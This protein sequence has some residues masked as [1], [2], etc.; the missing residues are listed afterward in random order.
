MNEKFVVGHGSARRTLS[1]KELGFT[2]WPILLSAL[3]VFLILTSSTWYLGH[4]STDNLKR[5]GQW[6][7]HTNEVRL[8]IAN[9][10]IQTHATQ[11]AARAVIF[12]HKD[13]NPQ[14]HLLAEKNLNDSL[15][16]L[17]LLTKDNPEQ[18]E[19]LRRMEPLLKSRSAF[20][21]DITN[22]INVDGE[23][24]SQL[25]NQLA[26]ISN[27]LRKEIQDFDDHEEALLVERTATQTAISEKLE[28]YA[29]ALAIVLTLCLCAASIIIYQA[30]RKFKDSV[31]LQQ[32]SRKLAEEANRAKSSFVASVTHELRTPLTSILG[33]ADVLLDLN[34]STSDRFDAIQTIRRNGGHL[35]SLVNDVLDLSKIEASEFKLSYS[36]VDLLHL[37]ADIS[38]LM[39]ERLRGK[40]VSM[41]FRSST[42][43]SR[44]VNTDPVRVKQVIVNLLGNAIKF[45]DRG[46]VIVA[47]SV[48]DDLLTVA[49]SDTG[50]GMTE[51]DQK[52]LFSPFFQ[53]DGITSQAYGGTGLGLVISRKITELFDG[54]L[55][56]FSKKQAGSTFTF[57][58]PYKP[59]G[60]EIIKDLEQEIGVQV[61]KEEIGV[62]QSCFIGN[63][64]LVE[65]SPDSRRLIER[66]LK[67]MG[68]TISSADNGRTA[69]EMTMRAFHDKEPYDLVLMDMQLPEIDGYTA[70]ASLRARGYDLPIVALT[71]NALEQDRRRALDVGCSD[72]LAKPIDL[73]HMRKVFAQ[74][75]K[76]GT[77]PNTSL[78]LPVDKDLLLMF[79]K[80]IP[81]RQAILHNY[82]ITGNLLAL[83]E[84]AHKL[85]SAAGMYGFGKVADL[86][87]EVEQ[88]AKTDA[89]N[90]KEEVNRLCHLLGECK[91]S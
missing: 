46:A 13:T 48:E 23:R 31:E 26:E 53:G 27:Q 60:S 54:R 50:V 4:K 6:V 76:Q 28:M 35:L 90:L 67:R 71:A 7:S 19:R 84:E 75:L 38:S 52:R 14:L 65:D 74:Y 5:A 29:T 2:L 82:L 40:S 43:F 80:G 88:L 30:Y 57:S 77:G 9:F 91:I 73:G 68:L 89:P 55:T 64:L 63:I 81:E 41:I 86:S 12:G 18:Q 59:E 39:R 36:K 16:A 21:E 32:H 47:V 79:I 42:P 33:F 66:F 83:A 87:R 11:S 20:I 22:S 49:I 70:V 85:I 25:L 15:Q 69:I 58:I 51:E 10:L 56:V 72:F 37:F 24:K 61:V 17:S 78:L 62:E 45:T 44:Y 8:A 34:L 3:T 1:A